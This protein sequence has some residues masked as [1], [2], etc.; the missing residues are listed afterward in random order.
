M[1]IAAVGVVAGVLCA[2]AVNRS[3]SS[4]LYGVAP[5]DMRTLMAVVV[6]L[7]AIAGAATFSP[8]RSGARVDPAR[9]LRSGD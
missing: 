9:A 2:L 6:T 8:A 5:T 3:L 7:L 1:S 4:L